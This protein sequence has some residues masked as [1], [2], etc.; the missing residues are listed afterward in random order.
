MSGLPQELEGLRITL[1]GDIQVDRFTGQGKVG[2]VHSIV[3]GQK[4]E[5]LL[6]SGDLVTRG[7]EYL[8]E[9]REAI[10]GMAGSVASIAV[11]G[12][13]DHWS[14]PD[15]LRAIQQECGWTF[16]ENHHDMLA[17]RGRT[18]LI[19]GVTHI[20][21]DRLPGS[22]LREFLN[23]APRQTCGSCWFTNRPKSWCSW[24]PTQATTWCSRGIRT[25]VKSSF[26]PWACR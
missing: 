25:E 16:L 20:Y 1:V 15:D 19:S 10:C 17:Y 13:H 24:R 18:I 14:A 8:G 6:S 26:T 9:A 7:R 4:P 22:A 12:D 5:L 2:R 23:A 3:S 11:M 21:S